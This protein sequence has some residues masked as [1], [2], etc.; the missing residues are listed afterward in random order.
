MLLDPDL[1]LSETTYYILVSLAPGA[2]HGYAIMKEVQALSEGRVRLSTGTLYGALK[3]LLEHGW[4]KRVADPALDNSH[5]LRKAYALTDHGRGVLATE[6][7]RLNQLVAA[8][9]RRAVEVQP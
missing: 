5:R 3:R 6:I 7:A 1:P 2:R 4:V 8:A 9:Q